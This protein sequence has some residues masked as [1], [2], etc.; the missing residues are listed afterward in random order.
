MNEKK[1][2]RG[3]EHEV[4]TLYM[5]LSCHLIFADRGLTGSILEGR[6]GPTLE[7]LVVGAFRALV[8]DLDF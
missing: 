2:E 6:D 8:P 1:E 5:A 3:K 4:L 7:T